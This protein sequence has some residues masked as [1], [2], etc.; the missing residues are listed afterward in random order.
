[1][2]K[3]KTAIF[4]IIFV[5][6]LL[7]MLEYLEMID[8]IEPEVSKTDPAHTFYWGLHFNPVNDFYQTYDQNPSFQ[9]MLSKK[10]MGMNGSDV[11][12]DIIFRRSTGYENYRF[13]QTPV[14]APL[15]GLDIKDI[16]KNEMGIVDLYKKGSILDLSPY[17]EKFMPNY[18]AFLSTNPDLKKIASNLVDGKQKYLMLYSWNKVI[19]DQWNG[20]CYRRDWIVSY[21]KNPFDESAFHGEYTL[22]NSDGSWDM[23]SWVDNVVFPSGG[24]DPVYISDWEWMFDIFKK[25]IQDQGITDGYCMSL[26]YTGYF[27]SGDLVS[28]FGGGGGHWYKNQDNKVVFGLASDNFR[29]YLQCM[30]SWYAKGWIDPYFQEHVGDA[31][32]TI[33]NT[34][35]RQGKVGLWEGLVADLVGN[36]D[37]GDEY[38]N[39]MVVYAARDPINDTYGTYEQKNVIPYCF[40]QQGQEETAIVI[41]SN[42]LNKDINALF[43]FL[44]YAY[45]EEGMLLK[46]F[47]LSKEQYTS[48]QNEVYK[49]NGLTEG[50][51]TDTMN[52][53]GIHEIKFDDAL[54]NNGI[55]L[56]AISCNWL[57]GLNGVPD[58]IIEIDRNETKTWRHNMEEWVAY[59]NTGS[60]NISIT[61]QVT[62]AEA[63]T[64]SKTEIKV[65]EFTSLNVSIYILGTKDPYNDAD[66]ET[67]LQKLNQYNPDTVTQIY[68]K[69]VDQRTQ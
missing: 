66:W 38:N 23:T 29:T 32:Y 3:W 4:L 50:A 39:G 46:H 25:A 67:F 64:I 37:M 69:A 10:W 27:E 15:V 6:F 34:K 63:S 24:T 17:V 42:V 36:L 55:L 45:S 49:K 51:Y 13:Y 9:Y 47:G 5:A 57:F 44:D 41:S 62:E 65:R 19:P 33:D 61:S 43:H 21:G 56:S 58:N 11:E 59:T 40:S 18:K 68:Q 12:L 22:K 48:T 60:F 16:S 35:V 28:A 30:N 53:F 52:A 1:M 20:F 8:P 7:V 2:M 31:F 54:K 26:Y 14:S